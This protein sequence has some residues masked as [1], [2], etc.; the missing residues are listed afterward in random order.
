MP[1]QLLILRTQHSH[2]NHSFAA[3]TGIMPPSCIMTVAPPPTRLDHSLCLWYDCEVYAKWQSICNN[4]LLVA[5]EFHAQHHE[6][7]LTNRT[8]RPQAQLIKPSPTTTRPVWNAMLYVQAIKMPAKTT[9]AFVSVMAL[10]AMHHL[11]VAEVGHIRR[12]LISRLES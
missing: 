11:C 3:S 10:L 12:D 1:L 5:T 2:D 7:N 9:W 8:V 6:K 4:G